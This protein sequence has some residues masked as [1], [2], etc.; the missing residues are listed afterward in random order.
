MS[1]DLNFCVEMF[2]GCV[3]Y[4]VLV[5]SLLGIIVTGLRTRR[6]NRERGKDDP[7][8]QCREGVS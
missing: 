2:T 1:V 4:G 6:L 5:W 7:P 8:Q 3:Y